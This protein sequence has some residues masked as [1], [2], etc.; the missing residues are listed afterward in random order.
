MTFTM[1]NCHLLLAVFVLAAATGAF[2]QEPASRA[3]EQA[4]RQ[5]EKARTAHPGQ[6]NWIERKILD[7]EAAGGFGAPRGFMATFGDIKS[8]SGLAPGVAYGKLFNNGT[9]AQV[10]G[11]YSIR[12]FKLAQFSLA[13]PPLAG[14]R[15]RFGS[16]VR[17]Q[18][19][20]LL[21]F[22]A[23]GTPSP[24]TRADYSETKTEVSA[25]AAFRPVH[26]L[27]FGGS[28]GFERFATGPGASNDRRIETFFAGVPG[29]NADPDYLHTS[30]SAAIDSRDADGYSRR[31]T[32]L[33]ATLHDY[34]QQNDGPYSFQ[35]VDGAAEQYLPILRGNWVI[36]LGLHASTTTADQGHE[37]PFFLMPYVGGT[38]LRGYD[39][40][41]F[42]D[43][44][45]MV[46]TAEYR[47]YAQEFVDVAVFYD[48][49]KAVANRRDLDWSGL[50]SDVG[51]GLRFHGPQTTALRLEVAHG[52][53][54]FRIIFAFSPVG[55]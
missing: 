40:Y 26:L 15:L 46:F 12:N 29:L 11:V 13:P 37:V 28:I 50:Q 2:A 16:R 32:L 38:D 23:L 5:E 14:G 54:G 3:E 19:A 34:R 18:D 27:R 21:A 41:R 30:A 20:P 39:N 8:G 42:R 4:R 22:Y 44:H 51:A 9:I 53:E 31:G 49:G 33:R 47:W 35:R 48:A 10:K 43:R 6:K 25:S 52:R 1:P 55:G 45:S 36:Y 24:K 17:W 7:I